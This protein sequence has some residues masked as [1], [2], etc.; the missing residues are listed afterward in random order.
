MN[1]YSE[2]DS[3]AVECNIV[4]YEKDIVAQTK[5]MVNMVY[6]DNTTIADHIDANTYEKLKQILVNNN[7]YVK[8]F[9]KYKPG[10][11]LS[12]MESVVMKKSGLDDKKGIDRYFLSQ[13]KK[14][15]KEILEVESVQFQTDMLMGFSDEIMNL[16]LKSYADD[17]DLNVDMLN[18][19]YTVW[20]AGDTEKL[21]TIGAGDENKL[22][23]EEIKL[24]E[25]Y[26]KEMLTDRNI[27]MV[28]KAEQYLSDGKN[29]FFIVGAMHMVGE[30]GIVAQLTK[31]G[32]TVTRL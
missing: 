2:C 24:T 29:V 17:F 3:I 11:W 6:D 30:D 18:E 28:E 8:T 26:N 7:S 10:V 32:Y 23:D 12:L 4:E 19:L 31:K 13:A 20:K 22:T 15:E 27:G 25:Q 1:A 5:M 14:D 9:D 21:Y 16:L